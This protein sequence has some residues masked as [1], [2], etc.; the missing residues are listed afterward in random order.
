MSINLQKISDA[1]NAKISSFG[2]SS[3]TSEL[4][5]IIESINNVNAHGG[6]ITAPSKNA[7]P[8]ADSSNTG[9]I[10]FVRSTGYTD[11]AGTFYFGT[12][13]DW[14]MLTTA[15]DNADSAGAASAGGGGVTQTLRGTQY[16]YLVG[17]YPNGT[18]FGIQQYSFTSDGNATKV[19]SQAGRKTA[20]A[21]FSSTTHGYAAAG[22][23]N[24]VPSANRYVV[25]KFSFATL[26]DAATTTDLN[27][28][29]WEMASTHTATVGYTMAGGTPASPSGN[30]MQKYDMTSDTPASLT[31]T[32]VES[33]AWST[34]HGSETHGYTSGGQPASTQIAKFP[35]AADV[36]ATDV[37]DLT[38]G[39]KAGSGHS[40]ETHGYNAGH[41]NS[42]A[43][44]KF[45]FAADGNG[46]DVGDL[47]QG[48]YFG[49]SAGAQSTTH[50]Y[51]AGGGW[52]AKNT[53]DKFSFASDGNATDV[54]DVTSTMR[55]QSAQN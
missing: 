53:I 31:G 52:P 15:S 3:P 11:S 47:T 49:T 33:L 23:N 16:G 28:A 29:Q 50:A 26:T 48:R 8:L 36:N 2:S 41:P 39:H 13:T 32:M 44:D 24:G 37:G 21:G 34:G 27:T 4:V 46:T 10:A 1:I 54:G 43:I 42:N 20:G 25:E 12:G 51:C 14:S 19:G 55:A 40:S 38:T 9:T 30:I 6:V 7:L 45:P 22:D 18:D 17:G 35:F 5:K